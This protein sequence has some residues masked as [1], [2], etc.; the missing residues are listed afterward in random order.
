MSVNQPS[1]KHS[2]ERTMD[3][4]NSKGIIFASDDKNVTYHEET[5][6]D[7]NQQSPVAKLERK[8]EAKDCKGVWWGL[9]DGDKDGKFTYK[10][11]IKF[12][13]E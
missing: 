12:I 9:R 11:S 5:I 8:I 10:E 3:A 13:K 7:A 2:F 1:Y 6:Q 4:I